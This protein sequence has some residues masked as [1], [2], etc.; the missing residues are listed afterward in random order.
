[1]Q[2]DDGRIHSTFPPHI[3][4]GWLFAM[5]RSEYLDA[6]APDAPIRATNT[7][8]V[9][10]AIAQLSSASYDLASIIV[11]EDQNTRLPSETADIRSANLV[12]RDAKAAIPVDKL[13]VDLRRIC[14]D[15]TSPSGIE[16]T[17][18]TGKDSLPGG[19]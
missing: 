2:P 6:V 3:A 16:K 5:T 18:A 19:R 15:T 10:A 14:E 1:M 11:L 9:A 4:V 13:A 8:Y 17:L 12:R 7:G